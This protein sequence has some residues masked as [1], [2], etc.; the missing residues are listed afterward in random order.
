MNAIGILPAFGGRVM[1]DRLSSYDVYK[2]AQSVCGSHLLRDAAGIAQYVGQQWATRM[3]EAL[4]IMNN[5]AHYWRNRG[6]TS[7]PKPIRDYWV[8]QYFDILATGYAA[9]PKPA[10]P[11]D[12]VPKRKGPLKQTPAKNLLDAF[13]DRADQVLAFLDDLSIP[14]TNNQA[15]RDLRMA[16]VQQKISG[17]FRAED[18][19]T[20]FCRIRSYLSTMSKQGH[21]M[22]EALVAVFTGHPLSIAWSFW[23]SPLFEPP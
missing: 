13:L 8:A 18:S 22:L 23:G 21:A 11:E 7:V 4:E 17:T 14:F 20:C 15:E 2:C 6:A 9:Q 10:I 1:R 12:A 19:P 3:E 5:V 16:K